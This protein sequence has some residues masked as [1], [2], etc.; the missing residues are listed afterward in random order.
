MGECGWSIDSLMGKYIGGYMGVG[1]E[2]E[3]DEWRDVGV[4]KRGR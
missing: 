4:C 3:A 1:G 2:G